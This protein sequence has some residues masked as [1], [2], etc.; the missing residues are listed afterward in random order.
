MKQTISVTRHIVVLVM[1]GLLIAVGLQ[2]ATASKD[3][4]A[5][6]IPENFSEFAEKARS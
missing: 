1:V 2:V 5:R 3:S 6:M 4:P